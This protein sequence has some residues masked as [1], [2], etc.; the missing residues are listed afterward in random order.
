MQNAYVYA[1]DEITDWKSE[2]V[3]HFYKQAVKNSIAELAFMVK[4]SINTKSS[5]P[6]SC[7]LLK[8]LRYL[9]LSAAK[10]IQLAI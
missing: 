5:Q 9:S 4:A 1:R 6:R 3:M 10:L 2:L 7:L 8:K